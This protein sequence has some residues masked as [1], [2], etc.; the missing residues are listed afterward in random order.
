MKKILYLFAS[1]ASILVAGL[2]LKEFLYRQ[3]LPY[4]ELGIYFDVEDAVVYNDSAVLLYAS[5][6]LISAA[7]ATL[8]VWGTIRAWRK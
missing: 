2:L 4:N 3:S 6:S 1:L 5:L 8:V 7:L